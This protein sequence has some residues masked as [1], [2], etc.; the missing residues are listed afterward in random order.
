MAGILAV[1]T[2]LNGSRN[3]IIK[4]QISG[5]ADLTSSVLFDASAYLPEVTDNKIWTI[6]YVLNGFSATLYWDATTDVQALAIPT[7]HPH[8]NDFSWFG[9][10]VNNAGSGKTGDILITTKGLTAGDTGTIILEVKK[11]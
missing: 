1:S 11:K 8:K 5:D 2:V 6:D 4:I 10:L 3:V 7:D 9:G